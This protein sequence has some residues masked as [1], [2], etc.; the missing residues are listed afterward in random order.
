[1]ASRFVNVSHIALSSGDE[2][3]SD[4]SVLGDS[5]DSFDDILEDQ[6]KLNELFRGKYEVIERKDQE[7]I[8]K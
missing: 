5:N 8:S 1:M 3:D 2:G 6:G 4:G 7:V